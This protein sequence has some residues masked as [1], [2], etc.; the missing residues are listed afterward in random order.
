MYIYVCVFRVEH[1]YDAII[2]L[3]KE[4]HVYIVI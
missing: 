3:F 2:C 4:T 1:E